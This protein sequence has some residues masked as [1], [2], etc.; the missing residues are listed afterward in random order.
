MSAWVGI[1]NRVSRAV[2]IRINPSLTERAHAVRARKSLQGR[3]V[4]PVA[5]AQDVLVQ[6]AILVFTIKA[7]DADSFCHFLPIYLAK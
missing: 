5:V 6:H 4:R 7:G 1:I 3:V 2:R